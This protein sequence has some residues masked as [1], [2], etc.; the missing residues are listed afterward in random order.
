MSIMGFPRGWRFAFDDP[1]TLVSHVP[2]GSVF[3]HGV[4]AGLK[5]TVVE[6]KNDDNNNIAATTATAAGKDDGKHHTMGGVEERVYRSLQS[7]FAHLPHP[8]IPS[9]SDTAKCGRGGT[10]TAT[11]T[12]TDGLLYS[13]DLIIRFLE[14]V[15]SYSGY[16]TSRPNHFLIGRRY[17]AEFSNVVLFGK[18]VSCVGSSTPQSSPTTT[19]T[20]LLTGD[21]NNSGVV[22]FVVEYDAESLTALSRVVGDSSANGCMVIR[23][24]HIIT[25]DLAWGGCILYE[26]K[27]CIRRDEYSVIRNIDR[28]TAV[29]TWVA[30]DMKFEE[31]IEQPSNEGGGRTR[32]L[33]PRLTVYSRGYK[34]VF[35][36]RSSVT[37][38]PEVDVDGK[39]MHYGYG[40]YVSCTM[41]Q[42]S[43][44]PDEEINLK[45]GELIDLGVFSPL[46]TEDRK[47]LPSFAVKNYIHNLSPSRWALIAGDDDSSV[48][49][50]TDDISGELHSMAAERVLSYV[51]PARRRGI[52][53]QQQ[54]NKH[55][56]PTMH[57]R[58]DPAGNVHLLFGIRYSGSWSEYEDGMQQLVPIFCGGE[59]E[60]TSDLRG[61]G[62][63]CVISER[64]MQSFGTFQTEDIIA[65]IAQLRSMFHPG[66]ITQNSSSS[67]IERCDTVVK[68]LEGRAR[69][70]RKIFADIRPHYDGI[71]VLDSALVDLNNLSLFIKNT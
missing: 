65:C 36:V 18:I 48:Y 59:V 71:G 27:A 9:S 41:L 53:Q 35:N 33:L 58:L 38:A 5:I 31:L 10:T 29:E 26:R 55:Q 20:T 45:P 2:R 69:T 52:Q 63:K 8:P 22:F 3:P 47:S 50:L 24:I 67:L 62:K 49:D 60:V 28:A 12:T 34:F 61:L 66:G 51:R 56:Q 30:P 13:T 23:P 14:H 42:K 1:H 16:I 4:M 11:N 25:P 64:Y 32:R 39:T 68:C 19:K 43:I 54:H 46:R 57:V 37:S 70:L 44:G 15:G 7:A 6:N 17:C 21:D 40:V